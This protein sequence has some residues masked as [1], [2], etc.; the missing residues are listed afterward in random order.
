MI[1]KNYIILFLVLAMIPIVSATVINKELITISDC[2]NITIHAEL[3]SGV[4]TPISFSGCPLSATNTWQCSCITDGDFKL[5]MQTDDAIV[6][7]ERRYK[8]S[9]NYT[10]YDFVKSK[11]SF[12]V[13]DYGDYIDNTGTDINSIAGDVEYIDKIVYV[14]YT[15]YVDRNNTVTVNNT[16]YV[17][18]I[19]TVTVENITRVQL[20]EQDVATL[21]SK[22]NFKKVL[23]VITIIA[24]I[25]LIIM[26]SRSS[27]NNSEA[28]I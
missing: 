1:N 27:K 14:N 24:I 18:K 20:L 28:Q 11:D 2:Y 10:Q 7:K 19:N 5:I 16:V 6:R 13:K 9:I 21:N 23:L 3:T 22:N 26:M 17:D 15:K 12:T 4:A 8:I 25:A